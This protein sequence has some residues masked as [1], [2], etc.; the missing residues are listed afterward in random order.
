[1]KHGSLGVV[2]GADA[3]RFTPLHRG[4]SGPPLVCLHGFTD[5]W[6]TWEL[7]LPELERHH[8]VLAP[9]L[10]GHAG[11]PPLVGEVTRTLLPDAIE[12][13]MDDAGFETAHIVG[14]SLGGYLALQL[15]V[16]GRA[17]SVVALA[18]GG[19]WAEGDESY[20]ETLDFFAALQQAGQGDRAARGGA[21]GPRRRAA[22]ARRSHRGELRAHSC[23]AARPPDARRRGVRRRRADGR[24]R[25]A[26]GLPARRG[27]DRLPGAGGV[28]HGGQAPRPGRPP[29]FA[30][31]TTGSR[32]PTGSCSRASA[33]ARSSTSR[34]RPRG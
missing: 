16:R 26:R 22:G 2:R 6:R 1:M 14:N 30:T 11:G 19:G 4:G 32:M 23:R 34:S 10:V 8:D 31:A 18:P 33:T 9:T 12:R 3:A 15:A 7:V 17:R 25:Q 20:R 27:A 24:V 28:G 5:T 13:A 21:P 29:P